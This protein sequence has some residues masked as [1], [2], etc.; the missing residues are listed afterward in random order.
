MKP[1]NKTEVEWFVKGVASSARPTEE[2]NILCF[3]SS[4]YKGVKVIFIKYEKKEFKAA[5]G[6]PQVE[7]AEIQNWFTW[8]FSES[9]EKLVN[10]VE[11]MVVWL[12]D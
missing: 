7:F 11:D 12:N 10:Y 3:E 5:H 9:E 8:L 1:T 2:Y 6:E 4:E